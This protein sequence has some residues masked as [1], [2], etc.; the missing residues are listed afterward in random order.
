MSFRDLTPSSP[1][2]RTALREGARA[3]E[4]GPSFQISNPRAR[5]FLGVEKEGE[6]GTWIRC[7]SLL[8]KAT[9]ACEESEESI[10][11]GP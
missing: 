4:E 6:K 2:L 5:N 1:S 3:G 11:F 9:G 8:H 10:L 7:T